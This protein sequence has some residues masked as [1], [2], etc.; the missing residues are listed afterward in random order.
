ML[1]IIDQVHVYHLMKSDSYQRYIR[2]EMYK[3]Y[4]N[5]SK[6]KVIILIVFQF[7]F[8]YDNLIIEFYFIFQTSMKG[9][10]SIVSFS[11]KRDICPS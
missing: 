6:K 1:T 2:S 11:G 3:E 8:L 5:T 10:R 9:I 4:L 7:S